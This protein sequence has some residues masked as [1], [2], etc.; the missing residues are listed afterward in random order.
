MADVALPAPGAAAEAPAR[1]DFEIVP[2]RG[3]PI[4]AAVLVALIAAIAANKLT[5]STAGSSP[6]TSSSGSW[7]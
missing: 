5:A 7:P 6:P 2:L 1:P 3:L 4:V